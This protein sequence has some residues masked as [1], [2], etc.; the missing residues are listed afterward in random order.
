MVARSG[1]SLKSAKGQG[2]MGRQVLLLSLL[3]LPVVPTAAIA[4]VINSSSSATRSPATTIENATFEV[5]DLVS[6][7]LTV[8]V[9]PTA[10]AENVVVDAVPIPTA[11]DTS[12]SD[13]A[14]AT[15]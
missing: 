15:P 13:P 11:A 14:S 6:D 9:E 3:M 2:R 8:P 4:E 5:S 7:R 1:R 12:I 10:I